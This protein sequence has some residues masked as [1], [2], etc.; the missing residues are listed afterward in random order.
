[1]RCVAPFRESVSLSVR[2]TFLLLVACGPGT[3]PPGTPT[4]ASRP[5]DAEVPP[6]AGELP[7]WTLIWRDEFDGD[8]GAH[9]D[10]AKWRHDVGGDGWGNGQ[11]EF[12]TDRTENAALDG[13]G[14]LA[15]VARKEEYNGRQYTSARLNTSGRFEHA[16][17]RFEARLRLP[18]GQGIWPAFW[19]LGAD[20]GQVGWPDC[21]EIDI[22]EYRGNQRTINRGSLH[23]PGY[24]GGANHGKEV[25]VGDDLSADFHT[26]AI[27]WDPGRVVFSVDGDAFFT[28]TPA[29]LPDGTDWVY[30]HAQF[31]ILNVAVGGYY[32]GNPDGTTQFPQT[33]LADYIRVYERNP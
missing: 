12:D 17:G 13:N 31:I 33:M 14:H 27:E 16:Y 6:D 10:P 5:V 1:M 7:G 30:D 20:I 26:Y 24:S 11:L 32:S 15:I 29:D 21:G 25:D 3:P 19:L 2:G 18:R 8:A 28:A 22:M 4:D 9:P 23:G